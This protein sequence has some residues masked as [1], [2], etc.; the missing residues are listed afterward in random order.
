MAV[1]KKMKLTKEEVEMIEGERLRNERE[2]SAE[3][4]IAV[5]GKVIH[6]GNFDEYDFRSDP[7]CD[8]VRVDPE[9]P[10]LYIVPDKDEPEAGPRCT[11]YHSSV[12]W[13]LY[14]KPV[15]LWVKRLSDAR[16][17]STALEIM[18]KIDNLHIHEGHSDPLVDLVRFVRSGGETISDEEKRDPSRNPR[19]LGVTTEPNGSTR[20]F[21]M[22]DVEGGWQEAN[23]IGMGPELRHRYAAR[24]VVTM[25][26]LDSELYPFEGYED[27]RSYLVVVPA[28]L[29]D[30]LG[31]EHVPARKIL[32]LD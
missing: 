4:Y 28:L 8:G 15:E 26:E 23:P 24:L 11:Y 25:A 14:Q 21:Y 10:S 31:I 18:N 2:A 16:S 7:H 30:I 32:R 27:M 17:I 22:R 1:K 9:C 6:R 12:G 19:R 13:D 3:D 20:H 29:H 5:D